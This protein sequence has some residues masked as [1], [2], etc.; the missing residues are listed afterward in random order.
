MRNDFLVFRRRLGFM[1]L[2][3]VISCSRWLWFAL[4]CAHILRVWLLLRMSGGTT[5]ETTGVDLRQPD[6]IR[7][8]EFSAMSIFFV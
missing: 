8:V 7:I 3:H 4:A 5:P 1:S 2:L 6:T